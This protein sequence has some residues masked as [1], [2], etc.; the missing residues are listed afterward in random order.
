M[1]SNNLYYEIYNPSNLILAWR[2]ARKHKTKK[3]DVI[4]FEKELMQNLLQLYEELKNQT[5]KPL[6][7]KTFI[8]R[9]PKTRKISKSA[10]RDRIIHHA[11][12]RVIEP[13]FEKTFIYD[14][15]ANRKGKGTLFAIKRFD[16]FKRKVT[17]NLKTEAF[18]LK[19]D[20]RHYFEEVDH[21]ILIDIIGR[22][23]RDEK[24]MVL[25]KVI[26]QNNPYGERM[27]FNQKGMP[28]GNLTSQFFANVYLNKLDQF[29]KRKLRA[30]YYIRYIDDFVILHESKEHL[31][32]WK[33]E[34]GK[35]LRESLK[36]ELH[37]D[38][39]KVVS[40]SRG[41]DFVG[42]RNFFAINY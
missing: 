13:I 34:I 39:S 7:L 30:K 35:F 32:E 40:L 10:F 27:T 25:I 14:S 38:K 5:Y 8:L 23:I 17:N 28:P 41:A 36:L 16:L 42:F 2:K 21:E 33:I 15:C 24:T 31:E 18:C 4:D 12:V 3:Y 29:V 37:P 20:I 1:E 26:L 11:I 19:A 9:D 6:P 22:K